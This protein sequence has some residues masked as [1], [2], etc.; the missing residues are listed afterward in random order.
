MDQRE[1]IC[2]N[3]GEIYI[4]YFNIDNCNM[5]EYCPKCDAIMI[6]KKNSTIYEIL[7]MI[8]YGGAFYCAML[9]D[10]Y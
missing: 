1:Y 3:C 4:G 6:Q 8:L 10:V 5:H 9:L 2:S 7:M